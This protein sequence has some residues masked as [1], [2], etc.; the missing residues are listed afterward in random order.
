MNIEKI[1]IICEN[2]LKAH[3]NDDIFTQIEKMSVEE[4]EDFQSTLHMQ[5]NEEVTVHIREFVKEIRGDY[6]FDSDQEDPLDAKNMR[7]HVKTLHDEVSRLFNEYFYNQE[8]VKEQIEKKRLFHE[9][10][11]KNLSLQVQ[12][13]GQKYIAEDVIDVFWSGWECDDKA[14]LVKIDDEYKI[15]N[16]NHGEHQITDK[17]FLENKIKEYEEAIANTRRILNKLT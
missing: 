6:D 9:N 15:V 1:S 10:L 13:N 17:N 8:V 7:K 16:S 5:A 14:W 11:A 4:F 2:F 3:L 12:I